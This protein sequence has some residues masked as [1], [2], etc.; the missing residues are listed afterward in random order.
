MYPAYATTVMQAPAPQASL[1]DLLIPILIDR[2]GQGRNEPPSRPTSTDVTGVRAD[3]KKM[4]EDLA[5]FRKET[6]EATENLAAV[7][8]THGEL[9]ASI[10]KDLS[11]TKPSAELNELLEE[12]KKLNTYHGEDTTANWIDKVEAAV[13]SSEVPA[14]TKTKLNAAIAELKKALVK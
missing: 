9:I 4:Q 12:V 14:A 13:E 6:Q 8:R 11:A 2:I 5:A 7:A 1:A 3:I 10:R